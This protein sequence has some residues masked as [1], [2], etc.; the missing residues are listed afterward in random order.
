MTQSS[1]YK[2]NNLDDGVSRIL[3]ANVAADQGK[4]YF[5]NALRRAKNMRKLKSHHAQKKSHRD[6]FWDGGATSLFAFFVD[7]VLLRDATYL[8][9]VRLLQITCTS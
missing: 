5:M 9:M 8:Q 6:F 4:R 1:W 2:I 3:E 7:S